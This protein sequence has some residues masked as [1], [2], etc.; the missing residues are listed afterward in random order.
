MAP[1]A[2]RFEKVTKR[3]SGHVAVKDLSFEV[4]TGGIFGL[5]G[6]NGAGKSTSIRMMMDIIEPDEGSMSLSG[7]TAD[8]LE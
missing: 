5:L 1:A 3:F 2:V 4:P 6:P 8:L 7:Q